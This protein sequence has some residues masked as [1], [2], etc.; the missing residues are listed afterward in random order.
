[1]IAMLKLLA[2]VR[3]RFPLEHS[4]DGYPFFA[5]D[6]FWHIYGSTMKELITMSTEDPTYEFQKNQGLAEYALE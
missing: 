6:D 2:T 1:M 5:Y 4:I 3:S